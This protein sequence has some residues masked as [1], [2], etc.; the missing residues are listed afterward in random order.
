MGG[1]STRHAAAGA[2]LALAVLPGL[3]GPSA[4][5][6]LDL[7]AVGPAPFVGLSAISA[8]PDPVPAFHLQADAATRSRAVGCLA[9]AVYYEAAS[10]PREGREAVA[11]V[12]LNRVRHPNYPKSVCGVVFEGAARMTGCQFTFTC[13]GSLRR[14]PDPA[15]WRDAVDVATAALDGFVSPSVGG[16]THYHAVRVRPVWSD[17]MTPT[18][19][20]G[21]HQ[22]YRLPGALGSVV[23]LAGVYA[24]V[25]PETGRPMVVARRSEAGQGA[26]GRPRGAAE[27][28]PQ[29]SRFSIWGV[30]VAD[31]SPQWDGGV[32]V[33]DPVLTP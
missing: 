8:I 25:E 32:R 28:V 30:T 12:V 9:Q 22:F 19:R 31:V 4:A 16:S 15:G 24:G 33:S 20:I 5:L 18:R 7:P 29:A 23:A 10:E 26:L 13:D 27:A 1:W 6:A 17:A 3:D 21:A 14:M 2:T 11:Q